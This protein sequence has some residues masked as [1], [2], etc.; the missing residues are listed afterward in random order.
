MSHTDDSQT[1]AAP[2]HSVAPTELPPA[3]TPTL[4]ADAIDHQASLTRNVARLL[5]VELEVIVRFGATSAPL[6]EVVGMGIGTLIE[7]KR[8]VD[9]PVEILVNG[10]LLA[11]GEVVVVDG[12]YGVRITDINH[13]S[14]SAPALF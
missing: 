1:P 3:E 13:T 10:H 14:Q 11:C 6:R 8:V 2:E 12:Y 9:E 4:Q 7:L 5:D